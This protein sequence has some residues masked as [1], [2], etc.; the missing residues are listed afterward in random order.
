[1][2]EHGFG[3]YAIKPIVE[4]L[5]KKKYKLFFY[6]DTS[7]ISEAV[8]YL[9]LNRNLTYSVQSITNKY[10]STA[11]F[12][13]KQLLVNSKFSS[14]YTRAIQS[15]T[16]LISSVGRVL[17]K[18]PKFKQK[19]VNKFYH[20]FWC[21]FN[22]YNRFNT[23]NL[24]VV[25]STNNTYFLNSYFNN[26]Y[27]IVESWDHPAKSP[28]FVNPLK[29]FTWNKELC[30]DIKKFQGNLDCQIIYPLKFRYINE[31]LK[32]ELHEENLGNYTKD[33][34]FIEIN[35]FILYICTYSNFSGENLFEKELLLIEKILSIC[36]KNGRYLYVRPHP[37]F[38]GNEFDTLKKS[39]YLFIGKPVHKSSYSCIFNSEDHIFKI[40]LLQK[41]DLIIN[42]GTTL[43]LE[44]SL[45]NKRIVQLSLNDK[46][47][48]GF[49]KACKNYHISNYLLKNKDTININLE[50]LKTLEKHILNEIISKFSIQLKTS[51]FNDTKLCDTVKRVV[52]HL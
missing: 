42:V 20:Y 43:V 26:I 12:L 22:F 34:D 39:S 37:H 25:T 31:F 15:N 1:M 48:C 5:K 13:L 24:L 16:G 19:Y 7:R 50:N 35:S 14:Q 18:L 29:V 44:A 51:F 11:D 36:E 47:F 8:E 33:I 27:L 4:E 21:I 17:S 32:N 9:G 30:N 10:L 2:C 3:M 52:S 46:E 38:I 6:T 45:L 49:S 41:A 28:F 23:Q 40:R